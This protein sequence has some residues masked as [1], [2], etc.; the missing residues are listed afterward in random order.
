MRLTQMKKLTSSRFFL[1]NKDI[2]VLLAI[3]V[4]WVI[5]TYSALILPI[6]GDEFYYS[7]GSQAY[8]VIAMRELALYSSIGTYKFSAA[9]H[10]FNFFI[11]CLFIFTIRWFKFLK[12][13]YCIGLVVGI[14]LLARFL[15]FQFHVAGSPHPPFQ[16]F[17]IWFSTAL[18]G[19]SDLTLRLPQLLG[20]ICGTFFVYRTLLDKLGRIYSLVVAL[21]VC[22][23]PLLIHV[24]TIVEGSIWTSLLAIIF[25]FAIL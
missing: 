23:T 4:V 24:A 1:T 7:L 18:F 25:L 16:L 22:S 10:I 15:A 9:L 12:L 3:T 19:V 17:P 5:V 21:A 2:L 14:T 20:L 8:G 11:L 6:G 13:H